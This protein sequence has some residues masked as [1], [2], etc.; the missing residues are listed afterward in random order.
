M[1][2]ATGHEPRRQKEEEMSQHLRK[3]FWV[4]C[5]VSLLFA[6][7]GCASFGESD[8]SP[9][10]SGRVGTAAAAM[11]TTAADKLIN[12]GRAKLN[13]WG[14]QCKVWVQTLVPVSYGV[15]VPST[16]SNQF[17]WNQ[18]TNVTN[19]AQWRASY[20]NGRIGPTT[21]A[22]GA[23]TNPTVY[24]PNNDPQIIV[25]YADSNNVTATLS[26]GGTTI[27]VTT[28]SYASKGTLSNIASFG[29]GNAT[30][31]VTNNGSSDVGN[32]IAVVLSH[33]RFKSDWETARRGDAMQMY[34][35]PG[36][37]STPHTVLVQTDYNANGGTSCSGADNSPVNTEGC[38]WLDSNWNLDEI[39]RVH[40]YSMEQMIKATARNAEYGFTVY[41]F[42]GGN[43]GPPT[44]YSYDNN[45]YTCTGPVTGGEQTDWFYTCENAGTE[46]T[47]G[48]TV[49]ALL[50]IDNVS[51]NHRFRTDFYKDGVYQW[52]YITNWNDVGEWGWSKSYSWPGL[53]NAQPGNW[54]FDMFVDA[55]GGFELLDSLS[56]TVTEVP[57]YTYNDN[58]YTCE[59]P[60]TGDESTN[61][62]YTCGSP[63]LTFTQGETVYGLVRINNVMAN[64]RFRVDVY[65]NDVYQWQSIGNWSDVGE[66]GWEKSYFWPT[67]GNAQPGNW[68][69]KVYLDVGGGFNL[70]DTMAFTVNEAPPYVYEGIASTCHSISGGE[71]TNW[72]YTCEDSSGT[73]SPGDTVYGMAC[74]L[75]VYA[76]HR[77]KVE[78]YANGVFQW[79]YVTD[80]SDVGEW[81][82]DHACFFP[83]TG[84]VWAGWWEYKF[85][86]DAGNGFEYID[87]A[88]FFVE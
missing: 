31:T 41:R 24:I 14:D 67:M 78:T 86:V 9:A 46:F 8:D 62:V 75:N 40:N 38:N 25:L 73:F 2:R 43:D 44:N 32:V 45:G 81:G 12:D 11:S 13:L 30:L 42:S 80:W 82:W 36:S 37:K 48:D 3:V 27:S 61:W 66:W 88:F 74:I 55:G 76:N 58:A 34:F 15:T 57:Q 19:V 56:F 39:V 85:Y 47:Q 54:R 68:K 20:A 23:S 87:Y 6:A 59:G 29:E 79:D 35:K 26:K 84:S 4:V 1:T 17:E 49:Y 60:I 5:A 50:R 16:A 53:S 70:L 52:N 22:A 69:F 72:V 10:E 33:S 83:T 18:G 63:K 71:S 21:L 64:H 77:W 51:T 28:G 7:L 65:K